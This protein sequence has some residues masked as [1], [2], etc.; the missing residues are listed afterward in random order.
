M[1]LS[2]VPFFFSFFLFPFSFFLFIQLGVNVLYGI[3]SRIDAVSLFIASGKPEQT[4]I[5]PTIIEFTPL[6]STNKI[7][8]LLPTGSYI[9]ILISYCPFKK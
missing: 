3:G 2:L 7:F 6:L 5:Y 8:L 4:A 1:N 9:V